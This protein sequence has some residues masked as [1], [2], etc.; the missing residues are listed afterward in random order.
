MVSWRDSDLK[1]CFYCPLVVRSGL[2]PLAKK[3][4]KTK[5]NKNVSSETWTKSA[6]FA[7][8][9]RLIWRFQPLP[10]GFALW[11]SNVALQSR[12]RRPL[13]RG[14]PPNRGGQKEEPCLLLLPLL[15][16]RPSLTS[17]APHRMQIQRQIPIS[18]ASLHLHSPPAKLSVF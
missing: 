11:Y 17:Q 14:S 1:G 8:Q 12:S 10:G 3:T 9:S 13:L 2:T 4:P 7:L 5:N 6:I 18:S 15:C 16:S